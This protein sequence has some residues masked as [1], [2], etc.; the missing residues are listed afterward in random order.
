MRPQIVFIHGLF[1]SSQVWAKFKNELRSD[2]SLA[3]FDD[4]YFEYASP[5]AR[6]SLKRKIPEFND[7]ADRLRT[8]LRI[9]CDSTR[10]IMLVSHS[11]GG[12]IVQR[13]LARSLQAEQY[14]DIKKVKMIVMFSCPNSG[15]DLL[16]SLRRGV[17]FWRHAQERELRPLDRLVTDTRRT[18][19]RMI[20][21]ADENDEGSC[22]VPVYL[23]AGDED[24]IVTSVSALDVFP[25]EYTGVISGDHSS[26]IQPEN[27]NAESY[28]AL[29]RH[30]CQVI[31][32]TNL[33]NQVLP[34]LSI[35]PDDRDID[36]EQLIREAEEYDLNGQNS[37][38]EATYA[39]AAATGN[40]DALQAYS[41]F[42]R[43]HGK[44]NESIA[45][46]FQV[47]ERLTAADD[48]VENRVLRSKVLSTIGISQRN[49]GKLQQSER[50]LREAA[51]AVG[52]VNLP[53]MKVRAYALDNLGLTLMRSAD[54]KAAKESFGEARRIREG[55]G[56]PKLLSPSWLNIARIEAREGDLDAAD[57][58]CL[59]ALRPLNKDDHTSDVAAI[60]S[61]QGEIAYAR[62]DLSSAESAYQEALRLNNKIGR[63]VTIA[64]SQ[65]QL[66]R[67]LLKKGDLV[68]AEIHA[69][70]SLHNCKAAS[71]VEGEAGAKQV[72]A[73]IA[74]SNG[75]QTNAI[76]MLED[77]VATYRDLGNFT[78]EAW[79]SFY[80]A[81]ALYQT[82]RLDSAAARLQRAAAL[83]DSLTNASLSHAVE[84]FNP[85]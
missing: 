21:N 72:L 5:K 6:L 44:L 35:L 10:P 20:V 29:R 25:A 82:D 27:I 15:S 50:S 57:D 81:E 38:A 48:N 24:R 13:F 16:L 62:G 32:S 42:Q 61:L 18:I 74:N 83:A 67:T 47:I 59:K 36:I 63:S 70:K 76:L 2:C 45:S 54:M 3:D 39:R 11:Q 26:I 75:D 65:Q 9:K 66:A 85:C 79:S 73:R 4:L 14:S 30:I 68:A 28:R 40:L 34:S 8:F 55:M 49:L 23:Y 17:I 7:L 22:H 19:L 56:D 31:D 37:Q 52:E 51:S 71:N 33:T 1:S 53:E 80:L 41:K 12:L 58:S 77:C 43:R 78:G 84:T 64:L 46:S 69:K 60:L